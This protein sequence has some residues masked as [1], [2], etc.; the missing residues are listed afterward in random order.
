MFKTIFINGANPQVLIIGNRGPAKKVG[1][2][3]DN[4]ENLKIVWNFAL[5]IQDLPRVDIGIS[6]FYCIGIAYKT[7]WV[8]RT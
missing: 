4:F 7:L 8:G 5:W 6:V 3:E 2:P 1:S